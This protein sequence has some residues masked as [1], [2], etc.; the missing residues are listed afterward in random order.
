MWVSKVEHR[1][2]HDLASVRK[3]TKKWGCLWSNE[4]QQNTKSAGIPPLAM[5]IKI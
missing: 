2:R 3:A 4:D 5:Q 1:Q